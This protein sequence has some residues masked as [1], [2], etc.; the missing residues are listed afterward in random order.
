MLSSNKL[1]ARDRSQ[2]Y[3]GWV[4]TSLIKKKKKDKTVGAETARPQ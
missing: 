2:T 3:E 4:V 1:V